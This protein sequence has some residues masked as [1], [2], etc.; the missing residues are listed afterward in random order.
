MPAT[1]ALHGGDVSDCLSDADLDS[2]VL[3]LLGKRALEA[4]AIHGVLFDT[5][6]ATDLRRTI[7]QRLQDCAFILAPVH[8]GRHHWTT[9]IFTCDEH[10][11]YATVYD[12]APSLTTNKDLRK[13]EQ[14]LR[15]T[16]TTVVHARQHRDSNECGLHCVWFAMAVST[17]TT[18]PAFP[19]RRDMYVSLRHWRPLLAAANAVDQTLARQLLVSIPGQHRLADTAATHIRRR[20][21]C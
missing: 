16:I 4:R 6:D 7:L 21:A 20:Y 18:A 2:I 1:T 17:S 10:G 14:R 9:A 8:T 12:S 13:L 19:E 11:L 5:T 3:P 15:C